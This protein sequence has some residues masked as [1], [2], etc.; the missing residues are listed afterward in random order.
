MA[1]F[2]A[3]GD[4]RRREN[5]AA[6]STRTRRTQ[7]WRRRCPPGHNERHLTQGKAHI[8]QHP[9]LGQDWPGQG[10][11][12]GPSGPS[13]KARTTGRQWQTSVFEGTMSSIRRRVGHVVTFLVA[14]AVDMEP[15]GLPNQTK[16]SLQEGERLSH[17]KHETTRQ[18]PAGRPVQQH[19]G[20]HIGMYVLKGVATSTGLSLNLSAWWKK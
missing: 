16:V 20:M 1:T 9:Q 19:R 11:V 2:C 12:P 5:G 8:L 13:A 7:R 10:H 4:I 14:I 6:G 15:R 3:G 17:I 18:S